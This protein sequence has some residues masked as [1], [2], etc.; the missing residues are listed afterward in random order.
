MRSSRLALLATIPL[1]AF[2][3]A[4]CGDDDMAGRDE[5]EQRRPL[6]GAEVRFAAAGED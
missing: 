3:A 4:A 2:G 6:G 5:F 1:L